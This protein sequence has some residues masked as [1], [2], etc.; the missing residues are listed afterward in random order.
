MDFV[1]TRI[2]FVGAVYIATVAVLPSVIIKLFQLPSYAVA[3]FFGGT[4][5]L[6]MVGVLL[7]TLRQIEGHLMLRHYDGFIKGK[8]LK[9][10]R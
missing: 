9:G 3:S 2:V 8:E 10:R 1:A 6:I 4:T 7:D 5:I